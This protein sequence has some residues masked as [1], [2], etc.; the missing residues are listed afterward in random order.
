[1]DDKFFPKLSQDLLEI[2]FHDE[3]HDITVE[4][5]NKIFRAHTIILSYRSPYL[6]KILSTEKKNIKLQNISPEIFQIILR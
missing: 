2:L 5:G 4:V 6:K 3:H 1:M